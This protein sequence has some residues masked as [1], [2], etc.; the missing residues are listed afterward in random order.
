MNV[1]ASRINSVVTNTCIHWC[2]GFKGQGKG[3]ENGNV[4]SVRH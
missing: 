2:E 3:L 4:A 1:P